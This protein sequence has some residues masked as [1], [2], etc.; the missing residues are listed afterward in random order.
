MITIIN[1]N[2]ADWKEAA[3]QTSF[4]PGVELRDITGQSDLRVTTGTGADAG[5]VKVW[6]PQAS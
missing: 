2:G 6:L 5:K 3:F 4:G 1:D